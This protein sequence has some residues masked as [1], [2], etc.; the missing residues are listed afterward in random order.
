MSDNVVCPHNTT[1]RVP[2]RGDPENPDILPHI[3]LKCGKAV[4][5]YPIELKDKPELKAYLEHLAKD[6]TKNIK[7]I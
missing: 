2:T 7:R 4:L 3:C 6:A 5:M 1:I